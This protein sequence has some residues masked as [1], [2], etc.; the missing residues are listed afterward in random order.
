MRNI[1]TKNYEDVIAAVLIDARE[2]DRKDFALS[3]YA[4]LNPSVVQLDVGDYVF[5]GFNG[6]EVVFEYKKDGDFLSSIIGE[7][8]HLHNQTYDMITHFDYTFIIV[9]CV[10]LIELINKRY[11]ETGQDISISQVNGAIAEFSTVSTVLFTQTKYQAFDLMVR[12]AGKIIQGKPFKYA[13]GKKTENAAL[14]YLSAMKGLD[15]RAEQICNE[16]NLK[17]LTDLLNLKKEDLLTIDGV[18]SK[19]ADLILKNIRGNL[20]GQTKD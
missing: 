10:N 11:Y 5:R 14:N 7:N 8:H 13:Y 2:V 3:Q 16:L 17:T 20:H 12:V 4:K 9:Q 19:K 6:V 1:N 15:K 18:G